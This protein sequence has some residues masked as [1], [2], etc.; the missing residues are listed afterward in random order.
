MIEDKKIVLVMPAYN[1]EAT[2]KKTFDEIPF[3][4]VDDIVLVDDRSLDRTADL[5][6]VMGIKTFVHLENRGYGANQKTCYAKAL[7]LGA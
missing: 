3:E 7:E 2:L 5:A 4:V 6:R 1:A